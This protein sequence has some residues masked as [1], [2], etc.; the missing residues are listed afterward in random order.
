MVQLRQCRICLYRARCYANH[1]F[2]HYTTI[3]IVQSSS[4]AS[5]L[6]PYLCLPYTDIDECEQDIDGC[7]TNAACVNTAG[8]YN[9]FCTD[10]FEGNG[11]SCAGLSCMYK[12]ACSI[13]LLHAYTFHTTC[14]Y[15]H[16][17][18]HSFTELLSLKLIVKLWNG[19]SI[20]TWYTTSELPLFSWKTLASSVH[21]LPLWIIFVHL[22]I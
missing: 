4:V 12:Q 3:S 18:L 9:C 2:S 8:S 5:Y 17:E 20:G 14:V 21:S 15:I 22:F 6:K 7:H 11:K 13:A 1:E 16:L 10:G 19:T